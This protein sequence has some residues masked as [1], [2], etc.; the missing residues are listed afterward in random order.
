MI[1]AVADTHA[2]LWY[3]FGDTRLSASAKAFVD[4][5]ISRDSRIRAPNIETVW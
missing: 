2:A 4:D 1:A 3:L 5:V